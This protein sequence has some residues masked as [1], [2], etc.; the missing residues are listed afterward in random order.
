MKVGEEEEKCRLIDH[1]PG[2]GDSLWVQR[3]IDEILGRFRQCHA[4]L[5]NNNGQR[6]QLFEY[7]FPALTPLKPFFSIIILCFLDLHHIFFL[8]LLASHFILLSITVSHIC[9]HPSLG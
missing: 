3:K 7:L 8:T 6:Q 1:G 9:N 2:K 5:V 4:C